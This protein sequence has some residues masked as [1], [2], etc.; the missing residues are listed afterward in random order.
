MKIFLSSIQEEENKDFE[1][2]FIT[3]P[4]KHM[5]DF[6]RFRY[7]ENTIKILKNVR[8]NDWFL[9]AYN[10]KYRY[11]AQVKNHEI[12]PSYVNFK[13]VTNVL[14]LNEWACL[15]TIIVTPVITSW[16]LPLNIIKIL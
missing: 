3:K 10:G 11:A 9:F 13:N 16:V 2:Y 7:S 4:S 14:S 12:V 5:T 1:K 15:S 6:W 8:K